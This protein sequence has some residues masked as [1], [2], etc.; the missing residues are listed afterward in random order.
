MKFTLKI[1]SFFWHGYS[2][3]KKLKLRSNRGAIEDFKKKKKK[4]NLKNHNS[5]NISKNFSEAVAG[6]LD[7][8]QFQ[9]VS[10]SSL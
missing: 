3:L 7:L 10:F 2:G 8:V 6:S 5:K 9:I 1:G 4:F